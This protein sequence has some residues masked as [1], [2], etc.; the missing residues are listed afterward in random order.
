[1]SQQQV[2]ERTAV[3]RLSHYR[4]FEGGGESAR[5][6]KEDLIVATLAEM[7]GE[8]GSIAACAEAMAVLWGLKYD[9]LELADPLNHL[10]R[11][12]RVCRAPDGVLA[13]SEGEQD[14]LADAAAASRL[15]EQTAMDEWRDA[16]Q[17]R[18]PGVSDAECTQFEADL[19]AFLEVL[20][21][22][23]GAEAALLVYPDD[24]SAEKLFQAS[25]PMLAALGSESNRERR[26]WAIT[27]FMRDATEA[28]KQFLAANLNTAYFLAAL[29]IDPSGAQMVQ[30]L[31]AGQRV[32]LDTNFIYRLLG[33]QG[34]RYVKA[35]ETI[36]KA[37]QEAGYECAVT[38]WTVDEY[39]GS[40]ERSRKFLERYPMPPEEFAAV[41]ADAVTI[42]D[43][44]TSY[45]RQVRSTRL[46]VR[47]YVAYHL[48]V[49]THLQERGIKLIDT[50]VLAI[51]RLGDRIDAEVS[52]LERVLTK[53][54]RF[55]VMEHDVKHRLLIQRLRGHGNRS[56]ANAGYWFMT[57]DRAL[58]RYDLLAQ[59]SENAPAR[60]LQFCVSAG[61]WFQL[62]E[63]FR[64][65]TSDFA[66]TLADVIASPY[67][68][69][70]TSINKQAAQAVAARAA[71]HKDA[72]PELAARLFMNA[73]LMAQIEA[74]E[75]SGQ[76]ATLID[77]AIIT[78]A[79]EAQE[80]VKRALA[81]ARSDQRDA[82]RVKND[83]AKLV[84]ERER[85]W[86]QELAGAEEHRQKAVLQEQSRA[87][88]AAKDVAA[89]RDR[90]MR[91][92][93]AKHADELAK[94][95]ELLS[96]E[97]AKSAAISRRIRLSIAAAIL[98]VVFV[99]AGLAGLFSEAWEYFLAVV[100]VLG[101]FAAVDQFFGHRS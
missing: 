90:E 24:P 3:R 96:Q 37:T 61:A 17:K 79:R 21:Q 59:R 30:K 22:R 55:E 29:T 20:M 100:A 38:P 80:E 7:D 34:P 52:V 85:Q 47:D 71:L 4:L 92:E 18:W 60:T 45:W 46:D 36:L 2:D 95:D 77:N 99:C 58:P 16:L 87:D 14:R 49:E 78:S 42:E 82:A 98:V 84:V 72:S 67:L 48:E 19:R 5:V 69:P 91:A 97:R 83:A 39:R 15:A 27:L 51:D 35:A 66:Q 12:G 44:V 28:Q 88:E 10:I 101:F 64:P 6:A 31:I 8:A 73:A 54:K 11:D 62:V 9:D 75:D 70:R 41:A 53:E 81:K 86:R 25:H 94:K 63:A 43:F 23:H 40:L 65:K 56:I 13:L 33:I 50:D 32:Y 76:Q 26:E 93:R 74:A 68:H 1:M 57:H 89:R